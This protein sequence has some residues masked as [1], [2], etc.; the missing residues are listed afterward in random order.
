MNEPNNTTTAYGFSQMRTLPPATSPRVIV[1]MA[2]GLVLCCFLA[3][4][5]AILF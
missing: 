5:A 4:A 1:W 3:V 2:I